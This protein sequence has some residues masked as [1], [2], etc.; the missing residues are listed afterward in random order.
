MASWTVK[1]LLLFA[2]AY[3]FHIIMSDGRYV[4]DTLNRG[5]SSMGESLLPPIHTK[6]PSPR[7]PSLSLMRVHALS[8]Y[9]NRCISQR[10]QRC[11]CS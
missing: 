3:K 6:T 11:R 8:L 1:A 10:S 2:I 9:T 5:K 4:M 7:L